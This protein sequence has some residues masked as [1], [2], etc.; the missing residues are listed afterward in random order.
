MSHFLPSIS[1]VRWDS[2]GLFVPAL[3]QRSWDKAQ[4]NGEEHT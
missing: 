1:F 3:S 2:Y 4:K